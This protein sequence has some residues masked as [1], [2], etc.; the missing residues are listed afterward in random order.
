MSTFSQLF[1]NLA[2]IYAKTC[3]PYATL[4]SVTTAQWALESGRGTS[5][6]AVNH[7]NF[8]GLKWRE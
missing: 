3:I 7:L 8:G 1:N 6:L 5:D 4:K 2:R